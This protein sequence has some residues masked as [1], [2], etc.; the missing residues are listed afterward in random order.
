M[1]V[2][3]V[4]TRATRATVTIVVPARNE[5]HAIGP[6]VASVVRQLRPGDELI[7]VDDGSL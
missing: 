6:L 1:A 2:S 5:A 4:S 3:P 7:V